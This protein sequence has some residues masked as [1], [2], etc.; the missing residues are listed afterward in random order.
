MTTSPIAEFDTVTKDY[1]PGVLKRHTI[2][3]LTEVSFK[4]SPGEVLGVVGPNRAGKT[5][6]VKILLSLARPTR[7]RALRFGAPTARRQT[8]GRVGFTHEH[9][10][11]PP[12]LS[13][14]GVL[15]YYGTLA[16][17]PSSTVRTLSAK[18]LE[19][20]SLTDR[21]AE[22]VGRF[23]KGMVARLGLAQAL[24]N[25]P[26]L[27]VLDEPYE[28]LDVPGQHLVH[29]IIRDRRKEGKS[30]LL[31]THAPADIEK[32]C[33]RVLLLKNGK[34]VFAGTTPELLRDPATGS[35]QSPDKALQRYFKYTL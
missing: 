15:D 21:A 20:V 31:I 2:R 9:Q 12:Y 11:F 24:V 22:P 4:L 33:D 27:L 14:A 8:L 29:E 35:R 17:V 3:A 32:L 7:G 6:L 34:S 23:S 30:V 13:A 16:G 1:H 26:D 28:G 19:Q 5:T 18:L 10:A 25:D